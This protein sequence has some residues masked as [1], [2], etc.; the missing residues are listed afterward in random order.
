MSPDI[1]FSRNEQNPRW[2]DRRLTNW[3]HRELRFDADVGSRRV[4]CRIPRGDFVQAFGPISDGNVFEVFA[5]HRAG[6]EDATRYIILRGDYTRDI[7]CRDPETSS[8]LMT[9]ADIQ[10][11]M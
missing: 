8:I 10:R 11:A 1:N 5:E 3:L 4:V 2:D 7:H 6:I 9:C